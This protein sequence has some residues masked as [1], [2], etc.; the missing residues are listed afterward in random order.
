MSGDIVTTTAEDLRRLFEDRLRIK[1]RSL[2]AQVAKA[3]RQLPKRVRADARY[4]AE[5][6]TLRQNPKLARMIDESQIARAR[7]NVVEH[8]EKINPN[9]RLKGRVL[10]WLGAISAFGITLFA[11]LVWVAVERGLV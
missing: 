10:N 4:I 8:L 11:V 5:A 9:D 1:G 2:E 3:G 7:Q 6:V